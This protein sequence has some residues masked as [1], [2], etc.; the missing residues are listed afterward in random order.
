MSGTLTP[1][2]RARRLAALGI[3]PPSPQTKPAAPPR[4]SSHRPV[5]RPSGTLTLRKPEPPPPAP[6]APPPADAEREARYQRFKTVKNLLESRWPLIFSWGRPLAVGIDKSLRAAFSEVELPTPELKLFLKLWVRRP[7]YRAALERGDRRV[8]LDS[9][10]AGPAWGQ[11]ALAA[12]QN[13]TEI[14][15]EETQD[16]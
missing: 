5:V 11:A 9:S 3:T 7:A 14:N 13:D 10:D 16:G 1:A 2:E 4:G 15:Q 6:A 8:H 12:G